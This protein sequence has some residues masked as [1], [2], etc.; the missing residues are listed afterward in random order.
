MTTSGV[1]G[2]TYVRDAGFGNAKRYCCVSTR[3]SHRIHTVSSLYQSL[4]VDC[5][6]TDM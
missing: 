1:L 3:V 2:V 5:M 4:A 6:C